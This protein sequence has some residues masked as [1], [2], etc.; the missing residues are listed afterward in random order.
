MALM[1]R[2]SIQA[3]WRSQARGTAQTTRTMASFR[4]TPPMT[5]PSPLVTAA[6]VPHPIHITCALPS[7]GRSA[8]RS[9]MGSLCRY[10]GCTSG[11]F[12][13]PATSAVGG[14]SAD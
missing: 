4:Q 1:P 12:M 5:P 3:H 2:I 11:R 6:A 14:L 7:R 9:A 13:A 8:A 10:A